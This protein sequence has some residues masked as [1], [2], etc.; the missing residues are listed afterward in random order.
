MIFTANKNIKFKKCSKLIIELNLSKKIS[1]YWKRFIMNKSE[2]FNGEIF[3]ISKIMDNEV[4]VSKAMFSDFIYAKNHNNLHIYSLFVAIL[5]KTKDNYYIIP[6]N[7]H[8]IYSLYG[9]MAS[10]FDFENGIFNPYLCV[11]RELKEESGL[12][13]D[14]DIKNLKMAYM[15]KPIKNDDY[16]FGIIYTGVINLS[17]NEYIKYFEKNNDRLDK[18]IL[19]LH[20]YKLDEYKK[21]KN[22]DNIEPYL[23]NLFERVGDQYEL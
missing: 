2:Y 18:E 22:M 8:G 23:L 19:K 7:R 9:G 3:I 10:N 1:E 14:K 16:L 17:K 15:E 21:L 13:I 12:D 20:F 11:K 6:E 4:S 5:L